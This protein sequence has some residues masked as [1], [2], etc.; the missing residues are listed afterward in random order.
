MITLEEAIENVVLQYGQQIIPLEAFSLDK[1]TIQNLLK[2]T[3]AEYQEFFP[4]IKTK[5]MYG[6]SAPDSITM[7][8][9]DCIG[10][11]MSLRFGGYPKVT[12]LNARYDK[13]NWQWDFQ[14]KTI[15]T[16]MGGG[17][18]IVTYASDYGLSNLEVKEYV[19]TLRDEDEL[20]FKIRGEFKGKSLVITRGQ[21]KLS[22]K[23]VDVY[24]KDGLTYAELEG[25]LGCGRICLNDL[26][27][28]LELDSTRNDQL[29]I[30]YTTKYL[31][32]KELTV[33]NQEFLIWFGSKL[34]T[35]IG[36]LKLMTQLDGM[37]FNIGVD[38]L[39]SR[40]LDLLNQVET[41]LK[42]QKQEFYNWTGNKY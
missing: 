14:T 2:Y 35:S 30:S 18:W 23:A 42:V 26:K 25:S 31:G 22:M 1:L 11:P 27:C 3:L 7:H 10:S 40:G 16:V 20:E 17:P 13:P 37:P 9:P 6:N 38:D 24:T 29:E 21:D 36:S 15:T 33:Q 28:K 34:L 4:N 12:G 8:I 39:R 19:S 41:D 32:V 5:T